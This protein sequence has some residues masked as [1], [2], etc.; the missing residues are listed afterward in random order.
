MIHPIIGSLKTIQIHLYKQLK[1]NVN[2]L[3]SIVKTSLSTDSEN[4]D[5][6]YLFWKTFY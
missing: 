5:A 6:T 4:L 3:L 1:K 2:V